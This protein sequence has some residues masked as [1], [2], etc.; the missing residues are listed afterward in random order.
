MLNK[1]FSKISMILVAATT[2]TLP[3]SVSADEVALTFL[4]HELTLV[5]EFMGFENGAYV[6]VSD[7]GV[8]HV[9]ATLVTCLGPDCYDM[10][11]L[12]LVSG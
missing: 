11:E 2:A 5:G 3:T 4:D 9:P 8:I 10:P 1:V 7:N 6:I 12:L